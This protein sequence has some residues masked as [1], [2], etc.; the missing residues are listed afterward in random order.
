[1]HRLLHTVSIVFLLWV[2]FY[3]AVDSLLSLD[4]K[5]KCEISAEES[6]ADFKHQLQDIHVPC[7][8]EFTGMQTSFAAAGP[9][10]FPLPAVGTQAQNAQKSALYLRLHQ[11][12]LYS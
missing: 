10:V 3:I 7:L 4:S 12:R 9:F 2:G 8:P 1:M 5:C 6:Q 11:L